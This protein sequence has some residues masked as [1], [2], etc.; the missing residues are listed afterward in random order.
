MKLLHKIKVLV[1]AKGWS[2]SYVCRNSTTNQINSWWI[3]SIFP[4]CQL[5]LLLIR[6]CFFFFFISLSIYLL[7][8]FGYSVYILILLLLPQ[9]SCRSGVWNARVR[10]YSMHTHITTACH[11]WFCY[12]Q[13][14]SRAGASSSKTRPLS[15]CFC[16]FIC[17]LFCWVFSWWSAS[18]CVKYMWCYSKRLASC[19]QCLIDW[20]CL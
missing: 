14:W 9:G 19:L 6:C 12:W 16:M 10:G 3:D 18:F 1:W 5:L 2:W 13:W 11:R 7:L 8:P 17:G 15:F 20:Y 4:F